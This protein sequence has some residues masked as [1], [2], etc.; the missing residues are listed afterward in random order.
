MP[1]A[2]FRNALISGGIVFL[3]FVALM[4]FTPSADRSMDNL[5]NARS[6]ILFLNGFFF[7][8]FFFG[9]ALVLALPQAVAWKKI[10]F[11]LAS[12]I[13]HVC[14]AFSGV[15]GDLF[16]LV[17]AALA[18]PT[19]VFLVNGLLWPGLNT[20][21][22]A[23]IALPASALAAFPLYFTLSN[24]GGTIEAPTLLGFTSFLFWPVFLSYVLTR[25][26]W[27]G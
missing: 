17:T 25:F 27:R 14:V 6:T 9:I 3:I 23:I 12:T 16:L 19:M 7:P 21:R 5:G 26:R 15:E 20:V 1:K 10:T 24:W 11:I 4:I 8:G 22:Q 13:L 18:G 2:V